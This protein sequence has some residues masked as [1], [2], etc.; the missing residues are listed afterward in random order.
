MIMLYHSD[1]MQ[2]FGLDSFGLTI[3][4]DD[5]EGFFADRSY[6]DASSARSIMVMG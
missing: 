6:L 5:A 4:A 2:Y 1:I 3:K